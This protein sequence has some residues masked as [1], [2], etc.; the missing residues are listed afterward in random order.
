M[1]TP[2]S[3]PLVTIIIPTKNAG[4]TL[5]LCLQ[6]LKKQTYEKL[7]II[8]ADG[9]STDN[10]ISICKKFNVKIL[11]VKSHI[12][13]TTKKN[14]A[15]SSAKGEY[16]YFIDADFELQ[17]NVIDECVNLC[18]KNYDAIIVPEKVYGYNSF[19]SR[20]R[21]LEVLCYNGDDLVESPRFIKKHVFMDVKGFDEQLIFGEENDLCYRIRNSG[22]RVGR[23]KSWLY[24]HEGPVSSVILRKIYYGNTAFKYIKKQR[25]D[26]LARFQPIRLGWIHHRKLLG[27]YP[28]YAVGLFVL[29]F[30]QYLAAFLGLLI[31]FI[32]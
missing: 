5:T 29:K 8:V 26:A 32:R 22:Y 4:K 17:S 9:G 3:L 1:K 14:L 25:F 18:T 30:I 28:S 11:T 23:T 20:C 10:T 6:S 16:V 19:W 2:N 24:H 21:Q 7:E 27:R 31:K 13:R 15:A 12:E